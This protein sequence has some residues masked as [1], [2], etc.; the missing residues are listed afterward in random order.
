VPAPEIPERIGQAVEALE[1][2]RLLAQ[3]L[4]RSGL[5]APVVTALAHLIEGSMPLDDWIAMVRAK[6]PRRHASAAPARGGCACASGS[7]GLWVR[8]D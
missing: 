6:Q 5:E 8:G 4:E 3:A 2:V 1:T 7:R